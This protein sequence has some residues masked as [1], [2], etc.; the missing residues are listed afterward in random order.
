GSLF[1]HFGVVF[2]SPLPR[3]ALAIAKPWIA[4][5]Y[6]NAMWT[7]RGFEIWMFKW[8]ELVWSMPFPESAKAHVVAREPWRNPTRLMLFRAMGAYSRAEYRSLIAPRLKGRLR[9]LSAR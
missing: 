6:G 7:S 1:I 5:R 2:Q 9:D 3:T 8:P 4:I